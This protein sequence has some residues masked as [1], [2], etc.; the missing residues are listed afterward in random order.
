MFK[1]RAVVGFP[2]GSLNLPLF[3]GA[4]LATVGHEPRWCCGEVSNMRP[5]DFYDSSLICVVMAPMDMCW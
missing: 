5:R 3:R 1:A 4:P 2:L